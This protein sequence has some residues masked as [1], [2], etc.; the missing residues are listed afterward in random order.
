MKVSFTALMLARA[1]S[2]ALWTK[3]PVSYSGT[4]FSADGKG[5]YLLSDEGSEFQGLRYLDLATNKQTLLSPGL[6]PGT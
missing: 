5:L 4:E 6:R 2:R 1:S 3:E